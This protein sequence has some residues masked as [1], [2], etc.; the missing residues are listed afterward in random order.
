MYPNVHAISNTP[1]LAIFPQPVFPSRPP[2]SLTP[3]K[4]ASRLFSG[5]ELSALRRDASFR[6][7]V[8]DGLVTKVEPSTAMKAD[9]GGM[10]GHA[11]GGGGMQETSTSGPTGAGGI[12]SNRPKRDPIAG[13]LKD[14]DPRKWSEVSLKSV[15]LARKERDRR[16]SSFKE[17]AAIGLAGS[18]PGMLKANRSTSDIPRRDGDKIGASGMGGESGGG[19][20]NSGVSRM[21]QETEASTMRTHARKREDE[22]VAGGAQNFYKPVRVCES[23]FRVSALSLALSLSL[24]LSRSLLSVKRLVFVQT[25]S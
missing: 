9:G 13:G 17:E 1:T 19:G 22:V 25:S 16:K 18:A 6:R 24:P 4:V 3:L 5:Q 15:S 2:S 10:G 23:C 7:Q 12:G 8:E 11:R 14:R 20:R 21:L